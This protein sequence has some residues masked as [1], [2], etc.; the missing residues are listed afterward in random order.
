MTWECEREQDVLDAAGTG[1]WPGR[2]DDELRAHVE[3]CAVCADVAEV[4]P[5]FIDD[6]D[7]AWDQATVPPASAVWWR[8]QLRVRREAAEI[9]VRPVVLVQRAALVYAGVALFALGAF[10][11]PWVR[12]WMRSAAAVLASLVPSHE[13]LATLAA[14]ASAYTLPLAALTL[15]L[16]LGPVFLWFALADR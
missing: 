1:R 4:A 7:A 10:L 5:L 16:V 3:S 14:N 8:A 11:G 13:I 6:R 12:A 9:A 15:C 2:V